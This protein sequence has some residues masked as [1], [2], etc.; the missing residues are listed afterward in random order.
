MKL[1]FTICFIL[2]IISC[3]TKTK[4]AV[5]RRT[6]F[7]DTSGL[8]EDSLAFYF[9]IK[10]FSDGN[11]IDSFE[12]NWFSSALYSFKEPILSQ[13]FIGH[14][15]YR[16]LWLRSFH[17]PVVFTLHKNNADIWLNTKM[18]DKQ[19]SFYDERFG[20]IS[21]EEQPE[22]IKDGYSVDKKRPDILVRKADR[23]ANII[24]NKNISLS[25]KA[26]GQFEI[27][28]AEAHFWKLPSEITDDSND[29]AQWIIEAHL[30]N[31]YHVVNYHSPD[32]DY[33]EL[34]VFLIKLSGLQERIY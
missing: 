5:I 18:L 21:K 33:K 32:G 22:Y 31:N 24:Y 12:Q 26:W 1:I 15:I 34:G 30:K 25:E 4:P 17:R 19:P 10:V 16:F 8:P 14:S 13:G 28:L 3:N 29:G 27:L 23:N 9:P 7:V 2:L 20:G 6:E 11:S